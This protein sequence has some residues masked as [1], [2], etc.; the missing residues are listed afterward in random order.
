MMKK[1]ERSLQYME[2]A[3]MAKEAWT[4]HLKKVEAAGG[5]DRESEQ[6][7]RQLR[8]K[9]QVHTL[10]SLLTRIRKGRDVTRGEVEDLLHEGRVWIKSLMQ[11]C[12]QEVRGWRGEASWHLLKESGLREVVI[13]ISNTKWAS[14]EEARNAAEEAGLKWGDIGSWE[15]MVFRRKRSRNLETLT[16]DV[17]LSV[18]VDEVL[19]GLLTGTNQLGQS[20]DCPI[21]HLPEE[22][23]RR[24][25]GH[26]PFRTIAEWKHSEEWD[27]VVVRRLSLTPS[28]GRERGRLKDMLRVWK[29]LGASERDLLVLQELSVWTSN[30]GLRIL[31]AEV[32]LETGPGDLNLWCGKA[33][34][35]KVQGQ[36]QLLHMPA[37]TADRGSSHW[38]SPVE[39]PQ[40]ERRCESVWCTF[41]CQQLRTSF[42]LPSMESQVKW[43]KEIDYKGWH[44]SHQ[45]RA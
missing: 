9:D 15:D 3:S 4:Q 12:L 34:Q 14:A 20:A 24:T 33:R 11:P 36:L 7:L 31:R 32:D 10:L 38:Q 35:G 43:G 29:T 23:A 25:S 5:I 26:R 30:P 2:E 6:V 21:I 22:D 17:V 1:S 18:K 16:A 27:K 42:G 19:K 28:N 13:R 39:R 41:P 8:D 37:N 44:N 45:V 40:R